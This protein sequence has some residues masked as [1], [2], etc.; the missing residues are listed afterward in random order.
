LLLT[1]KAIDFEVFF[2]DSHDA[3]VSYASE[4]EERRHPD[5]HPQQDDSDQRTGALI[6]IRSRCYDA[7]VGRDPKSHQP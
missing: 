6:K 5:L 1:S 7:M 2:F 3:P 4:S